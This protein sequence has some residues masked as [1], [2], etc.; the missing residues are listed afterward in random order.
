MSEVLLN[1]D[2]DNRHKRNTQRENWL[3]QQSKFSEQA[4]IPTTST[5]PVNRDLRGSASLRVPR[6]SK[7]PKKANVDGEKDRNI[8][9][10]IEN[11]TKQLLKAIQ[12][13]EF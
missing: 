5:K 13:E 4:A 1:A 12:D 11:H 10:T 8:T 7:N 3:S 2:W 6:A 9:L